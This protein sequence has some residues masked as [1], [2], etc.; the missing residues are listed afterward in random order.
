MREKQQGTPYERS[1][2]SPR[3]SS[4]F[5][6]VVCPS[7]IILYRVHGQNTDNLARTKGRTGMSEG[8]LSWRMAALRQ[9]PQSSITRSVARQPSR[10]SFFPPRTFQPPPAVCQFFNFLTHALWLLY[11]VHWREGIPLKLAVEMTGNFRGQE[12]LQ[13]HTQNTQ[14]VL[15]MSKK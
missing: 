2:R 12:W 9:T 8:P 11:D 15:F 5:T 13:G 4:G 10:D 1:H 14:N 3:K 7:C 6:S